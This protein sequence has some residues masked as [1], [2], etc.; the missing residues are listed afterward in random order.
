MRYKK[1]GTIKKRNGIQLYEYSFDE[2]LLQDGI[3]AVYVRKAPKKPAASETTDLNIFPPEELERDLV[4]A[5]SDIRNCEIAFEAG[6]FWYSG[7]L[8]QVRINTNRRVANAIIVELARR[9]K[10]NG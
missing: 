3:T 1:L 10:E 7:G 8:L 4:D 5:L 6:V 9:I 2:S